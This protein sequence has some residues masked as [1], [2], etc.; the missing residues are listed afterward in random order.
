MERKETTKTNGEIM[1]EIESV[2]N[3][4]S[5]IGLQIGTISSR[6]DYS[7]NLLDSVFGKYLELLKSTGND[8]GADYAEKAW[9]QSKSFR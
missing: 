9:E 4:F 8:L 3:P 7:N 2:I 1:L 5:Q 6:L